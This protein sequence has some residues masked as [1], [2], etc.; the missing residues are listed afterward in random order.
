MVFDSKFRE[1]GGQSNS[2]PAGVPGT[3]NGT[4]AQKTVALSGPQECNILWKI[5]ASAGQLK[6]GA[7]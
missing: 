5:R 1:T 7:D 4:N 6:A 2:R 3:S